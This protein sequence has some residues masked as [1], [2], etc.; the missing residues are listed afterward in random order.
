MERMCTLRD[1]ETKIGGSG[2]TAGAFPLDALGCRRHGARVLVEGDGIALRPDLAPCARPLGVDVHRR[3]RAW[4][5]DGE[6]DVAEIGGREIE[7]P[8]TFASIRDFVSV[9]VNVGEGFGCSERTKP[10]RC[11]HG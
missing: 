8:A 9:L 7:T 1:A 3:L 5:L 2:G 4:R 10:N 6:L 11:D